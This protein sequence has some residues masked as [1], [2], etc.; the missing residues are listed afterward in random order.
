MSVATAK[1]RR[2]QMANGMKHLARIGRPIYPKGPGTAEAAA[3]REQRWRS[4]RAKGLKA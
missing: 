3:K 1:R 4:N 2:R